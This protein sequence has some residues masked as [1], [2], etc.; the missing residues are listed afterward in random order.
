MMLKKMKNEGEN[1]PK[2]EKGNR[3]NIIKGSR[4]LKCKK[5]TRK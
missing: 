3:G 5:W 4:L 2:K 1:E